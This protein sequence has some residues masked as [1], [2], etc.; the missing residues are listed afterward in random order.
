MSIKPDVK[1]SKKKRNPKMLR[2]FII[3]LVIFAGGF[4]LIMNVDFQKLMDKFSQDGMSVSS[5]I[6]D[7]SESQELE[8]IPQDGQESN[9]V[10]NGV[11]SFAPE[12]STDA[13]DDEKIEGFNPYSQ[14]VKEDESV[15][16]AARV[17]K[18]E[19]AFDEYRAYVENA[20]KLF[21]KFAS[22]EIYTEELAVL[23][24]VPCSESK[25]QEVLLLLEFYNKQLVE[26]GPVTREVVDI[27][28]LDSE[29]LEKIVKVKKVRMSNVD[30]R[31]LK[32][33][34]E[35]KLS[36]LMDYIFSTSL[37]KAFMNK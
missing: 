6:F 30:Q 17:E 2:N 33:K 7:D 8:S 22:D 15:A 25:A 31:E 13:F 29:V 5:E 28:L 19:K 34:I 37:Q 21:V 1:H 26:Q 9:D 32:E 23:K 4:A 24:S 35:A 10:G 3:V 11:L 14:I 12:D 16:N 27:K 18:L 20:N 36:V